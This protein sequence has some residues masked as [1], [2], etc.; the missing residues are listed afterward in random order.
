MA[1]RDSA[2]T[3]PWFASIFAI[4]PNPPWCWSQ[5][6]DSRHFWAFTA[7][8]PASME[9]GDDARM[10]WQCIP[11]RASSRATVDS[12]SAGLSSN[13]H[14]RRDDRLS[15][16]GVPHAPPRLPPLPLPPRQHRRP[17]PKSHPCHLEGPAHRRRLWYSPFPLLRWHR[18]LTIRRC[19]HLSPGRHPRLSFSRRALSDIEA[20]QSSRKL[21]IWQ[22]S[23]RCLSI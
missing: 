3:E 14:L 2:E 16:S 18:A 20:R 8:C 1:E 13:H 7:G 22:G 21:G 4:T 10:V 12:V 5:P 9:A 17:P 6:P 23:I 15:A 11:M 19:W